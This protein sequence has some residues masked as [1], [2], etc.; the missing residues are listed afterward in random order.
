MS[1]HVGQRSGRMKPVTYALQ[2]RGVAAYVAPGV[3]SLRAHAPGGELT[4][5]L[6]DDGVHGRYRGDDG[7]EA[8]MEARIVVADGSFEAAGSINFGV[9]HTLRF[10]ALGGTLVATPD[11]HI[12]QG[13]AIAEIEGGTGQFEHA[14]GRIT[15]NFVLSDTGELTDHQVG[16][17]F[18]E[19]RA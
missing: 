15:S 6:A 16:L 7:D 17:V 3:L 12:R 10:R 5:I 1:I 19:G 11:E 2:F 18:T 14:S 8:L 4:T 9:R 13:T